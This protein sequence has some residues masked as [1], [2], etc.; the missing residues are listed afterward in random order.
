MIGLTHGAF[1]L[2]H[3]SHLDLLKRSAAI[4]DYLI[5]GVES[6]ECIS[7]Y[8]SYKQPIIEEKSRMSIIHELDCVDAAFVKN[9]PLTSES[10]ITL[11]RN[12]MI[13]FVTIG[14]K[15]AIEEEI[16]HDTIR[17]GSKPIKF[18]TEQ[19]YSTSSIIQSIVDKYAPDAEIS[20][21]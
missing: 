21:T 15:Y 4:C 14:H 7:L 1:D 8:K 3:Y 12:L 13:D 16:K 18:D 2:F 9:I 11:Y 5:V 20:F 19:R 17:A 10:R 6:D